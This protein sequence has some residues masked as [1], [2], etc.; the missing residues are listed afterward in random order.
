[1]MVK[2]AALLAWVWVLSGCASTSNSKYQDMSELEKP[3]QLEIVAAEPSAENTDLEE[4]K[5]NTRLGRAVSLVDDNLSIALSFEQTW[6][7]LE[8]GLRLNKIEI[9]DRDREKGQYYVM[10]D[11]DNAE[12]PSN[13][14]GGFFDGLLA[15]NKYPQG[16]YLLTLTEQS[17]R[18]MRVK[19]QLVESVTDSATLDSPAGAV[20]MDDGAAKLLKRL[21]STLHDELPL[22]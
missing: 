1:M 18:N 19:A 3:P 17:P 15:D 6:K 16:K 5:A 22:D 4:K 12:H 2:L 10:F 7:L 13:V 14:E 20:A 21:Y 11:P 8:L 9:S